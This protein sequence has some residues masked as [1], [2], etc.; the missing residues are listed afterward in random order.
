M[1]IDTPKEVL[2]DPVTDTAGDESFSLTE[3][4]PWVRAWLVRNLPLR[5]LLPDREPAYVSSLLY[6]MGVLR[7]WA[8]SSSPWPAEWC[9][10]SVASNGGT[11]VH[12]A[13][14]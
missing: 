11:R 6:T 12:S 4:S 8:R 3:P 14:S 1:S 10:R 13:G 9:W 2:T 7:R 5:R